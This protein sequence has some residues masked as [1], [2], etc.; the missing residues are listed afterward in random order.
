MRFVLSVVGL[1]A[2]GCFCFF[3]GYSLGFKHAGPDFLVNQEQVRNRLLGEIISLDRQLT[4]CREL[5]ARRSE[6]PGER[7][8]AR[9]SQ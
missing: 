1:L 6:S 5:L 4:E 2:F 8:P 3:G 9:Q 7:P